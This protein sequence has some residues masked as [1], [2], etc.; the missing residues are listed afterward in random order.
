MH[1]RPRPIALALALALVVP[2]C[3]ER[4]IS[5]DDHGATTSTTESSSS[6]TATSSSSSGTS[7]ATT[8][9]SATTATASVTA[10][11]ATTST[12]TSATSSTNATD[13]FDP[14]VGLGVCGDF[15]CD[16][17]E[18][19]QICPEDC[20][21][22]LGAG[23]VGCPL[24]ATTSAVDGTS[25]LGD[26]AGRHAF[27]AWDGSGEPDWSALTVYVYDEGVDLAQTIDQGTWRTTAFGLRM[28][29]NR[30]YPDWVGGPLNSDFGA[31]HRDGT[32]LSSPCSLV[33]T[34]KAGSWDA[35]VPDDPPRLLGNIN[36]GEIGIVGDYDA[37]FCEKLVTWVIPE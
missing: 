29:T 23:L 7:A 16:P 24:Y 36:C 3:G 17:S 25:P 28:Y 34:S 13:P 10:T 18:D 22:P 11:D 8:S 5:G 15:W 19:C 1:P 12:S 30:N 27:F 31:L 21:C 14:D 32:E 37:V 20:A 6:S 2:A 4:P 9:A 33:T 35:V 26:F